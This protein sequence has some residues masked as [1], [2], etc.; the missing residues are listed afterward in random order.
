[1]VLLELLGVSLVL[2][3]TGVFYQ[4]AHSILIFL[5]SPFSLAGVLTDAF[6]VLPMGTAWLGCSKWQYWGGWL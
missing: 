5:N 1:M 4:N 6:T 3:R 2:A